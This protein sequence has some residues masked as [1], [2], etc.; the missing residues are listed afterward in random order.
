MTQ[1]KRIRV[2]TGYDANNKPSYVQISGKTQNDIN[3]AIVRAYVESGRIWEFI[4][5]PSIPM[6][7]SAEPAAPE[8]P[9][10]KTD[11]DAYAQ[12]WFA[13]FVKP[14]VSIGRPKTIQSQLNK[15][16]EALSGMCIED[17][18]VRDIA[19]VMAQWGNHYAYNTIDNMKVTLKRIFDSAMQ[20]KLID[21]NPVADKRICNTAPRSK[22]TTCLSIEQVTHILNDLPKLQTLQQQTM[23]A[24]YLFTGVRREELLGLKWEDVN[25]AK[26]SVHIERAVVYY[27]ETM[28]KET[29]TPK[30]IRDIPLCTELLDLLMKHDR[31]TGY[32]ISENVTDPLPLRTYEREMKMIRKQINLFDAHSR[33]FRRTFAT[34][35]ITAGTPLP[36]V[37]A[38]MGHT[39]ATQTLNS[40]AK[41]ERHS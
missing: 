21:S 7:A 38:K 14:T 34:L 3:D 10:H 17:I 23:I 19:N 8:V 32:I 11:F 15:C 26:A 1:S 41:V 40:Y 25:F 4:P 36:V 18:T 2:L 22:D 6:T 9:V 39:K 13:A 27:K 30:S 5:A 28:V 37:Q 20:D 12:E 24:L 16:C 35:E 33:E 29:K 31:Q